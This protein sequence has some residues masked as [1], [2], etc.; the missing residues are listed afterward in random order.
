[1]K[2]QVLVADL[3]AATHACGGGNGG[4]VVRGS[5]RRETHKLL[6]DQGYVLQQ[7]LEAC[8]I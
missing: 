3:S 5:L 6:G 7:E 4:R 8:A 1:M 2:L